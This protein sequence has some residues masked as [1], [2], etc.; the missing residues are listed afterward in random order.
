MTALLDHHRALIEASAIAPEVA[1]ARG[2]RSATTKAQLGELGFGA[3]QR[4]A[5]ALVIP[6]HDV[7]GEIALY[8]A[9]PDQPRMRDGKV[10]KYEFPAGSRMALDVPPAVRPRLGDPTCPLVITE[11]ARKAD[12]AVS[13]GLDCVSLVGTWNWRGSN[14]QDGKTALPDLEYVAINGREVYIAYDSDVMLKPP[15]H[16]ALARLGALLGRRD[17]RVR[18]V[19]LPHGDDGT[20]VGLDDF[21]AAGHTAADVLALATAELRRPPGEPTTAEYA[22][23]DGRLVWV[24]RAVDGLGLPAEEQVV[25]A[26]FRARIASEVEVDDGADVRRVFDVVAEV[27]GRERRVEVPAGDFA[28]MGWVV[29]RLDG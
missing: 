17:A 20:K 19:Y 6:I 21:L 10:A 29:E 7:R 16:A 4:L 3:T 14:A 28:G 13:A 15:V 22:E 27:G 1:Q 24:R 8:L 23:R 18:Y 26:H 12:A 25:L 9:R 5:P 2:Y 11:G